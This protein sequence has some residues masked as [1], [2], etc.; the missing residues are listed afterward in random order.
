MGAK[1]K[2]VFDSGD[3]KNFPGPGT[4]K[5]DI[6]PLKSKDP[7]WRIGTSKRDQADKIMRRTCDFPPP[8]SYNPDLS[9]TKSSDPKWGFGSGKRGGLVEGKVVSPGMQTYT[10][11]S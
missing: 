9:Q 6:S 5:I 3:V 11:P 4:Y 2:N 10:I 7:Q 1:L 8:G